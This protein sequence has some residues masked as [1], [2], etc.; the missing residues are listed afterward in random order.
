MGDDASVSSNSTNENTFFLET[1]LHELV[2]DSDDF[3][4]DLLVVQDDLHSEI[5]L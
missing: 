1:I 5:E 3:L 2:S 4:F